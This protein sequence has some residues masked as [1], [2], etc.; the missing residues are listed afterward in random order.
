[1]GKVETRAKGQF[2]SINPMH[3][4]AADDDD[5][6]DDDDVADD[7]AHDDDDDICPCWASPIE[8]DGWVRKIL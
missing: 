2:G 3:L 7:V 6:A 5:D 8:H 4:D 1:M